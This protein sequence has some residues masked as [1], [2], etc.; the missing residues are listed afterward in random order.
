MKSKNKSLIS[1]ADLSK[2]EIL[3]ILKKTKEFKNKKIKVSSLKNKSIAMIFEKPSTRTR[4]SFEVAIYEL[5]GYPIYLSS[6]EIQLS[7]GETISDTAR[8]LSRYVDGIIL[9]TYS[10]KNV[11]ELANYADIPVINALSDFEHPCQILSDLFTIQEKKGLNNIKIAFIGDG[12][13][14]VTNSLILGA[15]ILDIEI[16]ISSPSGYEPKEKILKIAKSINKNA[17]INI[18]NNPKEGVKLADVIY[19]DVWVSMGL[20]KEYEVRKKAFKDFQINKDLLKYTGKKDY[21]VMHCLPAHRGEEI[22]DDVIDGINSVVFDQAENRL[23][24]QKA[25]LT[26]LLGRKNG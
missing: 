2:N 17:K 1:I 23:H 10:H 25:I 3:F 8:V 5:G 4:V 14:N 12:D 24:T 19:T 13:N 11:I 16:N 20:E 22:T 9:R 6:N 18:T 7:R 26:L 15:S 21:I